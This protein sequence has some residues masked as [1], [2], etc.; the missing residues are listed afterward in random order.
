MATNKEKELAESLLGESEVK[1]ESQ[2]FEISEPESTSLSN[3]IRVA[4]AIG[5]FASSSA[6]AIIDYYSMP[7][8]LDIAGVEPITTS[9]IVFLSRALDSIFDLI[10]GRLSDLTNT[11]FGKRRPWLLGS[12]LPLSICYVLLW[13]T[14]PD[15]SQGFLFFYYFTFA[16]LVNLF[17]TGIS[18]PYFALI[19]DL[20]KLEKER[21]RLTSL[22]LISMILSG[23]VATL[24][25]GL[26]IEAIEDQKKAYIISG[27]TFAILF[28]PTT[29]ITF[30]VCKEKNDNEDE[31]KQPP[32]LSGLKL[33]FKNRPYVILCLVFLFGWT[34][35]QFIVA[36]IYLYVQYVLERESQA[37]FII[38]TFQL[39]LAIGVPI[40]VKIARNVGRKPTFMLGTCLLILSSAMICIISNSFWW[41]IYITMA[42]GGF[43][44]SATILIPFALLPEVIELDAAKYG[45]RREGIFYGCFV[46]CQKLTSSI[47]LSIGS[48]IL[49]L[50]GLESGLAVEDTP[51]SAIIALRILTGAVPAVSLIISLLIMTRFPMVSELRLKQKEYR[52]ARENNVQQLLF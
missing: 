21:T 38:L 28:I 39:S 4:F 13:L 6:A 25:H 31:G 20:T 19:P 10:I 41:F 40:W 50:T 22:S 33:A 1:I 2:T 49:G 30:F 3:K 18:V 9:I 24:I 45:K 11:R 5:S 17:A 23:L 12:V 26:L 34:G 32:F 36:N 42:I 15:S 7:F 35:A 43:G 52:V 44:F 27:I 8:W 51:T 29:L 37:V 16:T 14:F 47:G 48:A 46:F